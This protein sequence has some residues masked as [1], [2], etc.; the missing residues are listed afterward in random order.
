MKTRL[1]EAGGLVPPAT[2]FNSTRLTYGGFG[3]FLKGTP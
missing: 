1:S 3:P 2:S